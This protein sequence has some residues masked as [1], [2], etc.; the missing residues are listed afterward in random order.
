MACRAARRNY[1]RARR[2][3]AREWPNKMK[4]LTIR[5]PWA[6]LIIAGI[7]DVENRTWSTDYRGELVIHAGLAVD[8]PGLTDFA[9]LLPGAAAAEPL[10]SGAVL[11]TVELVD[12]VS[13]YESPW[14]LIDNW[15]WILTRPRPLRIPVP[16]VGRLGLWTWK[17]PRRLRRSSVARQHLL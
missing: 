9:H 14:A 1:D 17:P 12:V 15:H 13:G 4:A 10:P 3:E 7:K 6:S 2:A 8:R 5:Q 16:A 11:G